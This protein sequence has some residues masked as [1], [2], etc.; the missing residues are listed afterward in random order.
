MLQDMR[1]DVFPAALAVGHGEIDLDPLPGRQLLGQPYRPRPALPDVADPVSVAVLDHETSPVRGLAPEMREIARRQPGGTLPLL[2]LGLAHRLAVENAADGVDM[3]AGNAGRVDMH[4]EDRVLPTAR[5]EAV[6]DEIGKM[7]SISA[8]IARGADQPGGL[9]AGQEPLDRIWT[10]RQRDLGCGD[11]IAFA[12]AVIDGR[13]QDVQLAADRAGT[14][15]SGASIAEPALAGCRIAAAHR[16]G[17]RRH[18]QIAPEIIQRLD[19]VAD[20]FGRGDEGRVLFGVD[21]ETEG[22]AQFVRIYGTGRTALALDIGREL[23][24]SL[25]ATSRTGRETDPSGIADLPIR[26][27]S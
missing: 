25:F 27:L 19:G 6:Q 18:G 15:G 24:F 9:L 14:D 3:A 8:E 20:T 22:N 13:L 11:Q 4:A 21:G 5:I 10:G 16:A 26:F 7:P 23:S 1:R 17:D 2:R 12:M